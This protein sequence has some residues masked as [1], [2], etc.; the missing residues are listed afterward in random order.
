MF[1][2]SETLPWLL[3]VLGG[4]VVFLHLMGVFNYYMALKKLD[5]LNVKM[6]A[7]YLLLPLGNLF[8]IIELSKTINSILEKMEIEITG[9]I[10]T[11]LRNVGLGR[12]YSFAD[13]KAIQKRMETLGM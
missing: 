1:S 6:V 8:V 12:V 4:T 13:I 2:S 11:S 5:L 7:L 3:P 10:S 9:N